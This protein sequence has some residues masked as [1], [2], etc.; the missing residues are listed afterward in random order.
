MERVV[1]ILGFESDDNCTLESV[2]FNISLWMALS[3]QPLN[4]FFLNI[5]AL[6]LA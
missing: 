5:L 6:V 1:L 3:V 4:H 2:A